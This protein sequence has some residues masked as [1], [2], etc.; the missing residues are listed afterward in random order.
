M[1]EEVEIILQQDSVDVTE[2]LVADYILPKAS[3]TTLGG[4]KIGD[5]INISNDGHI[6]V[7]MASDGTLG[8]IKIGTGLS[9]DANGVVTASGEYELPQATK[10]T[11]GGV[12]LDDE[13]N[14]QSVNPVQNATLTTV[15]SGIDSNVT[16]LTNS[17]DD[18]TETVTDVSTAVTGMASTVSTLNSTVSGL[19]TTVS[20]QSSAIATNT[21]D[22]GTINTTLTNHGND[23]ATIGGQVSDLY[24]DISETYTYEDI[25]DTIWTAGDIEIRGKG[26]Y[27]VMYIQLE[28]TLSIPTGSSVTL[29]TLPND[30]I[31]AYDA[32]GGADIVDG[33]ISIK[34]DS[35][36][37]NINLINNNTTSVNVGKL[38]ASIPIIYGSI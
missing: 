8:L 22:I 25:D 34:V 9:I 24:Q 11:L 36:N 17:V 26:F 30:A 7:P 13:L 27:A 4:V 2:P 35:T 16:D 21:S 18:L 28:G 12:Y 33:S 31:P 23:I 14:D 5:N 10:T 19:S 3:S 29:Y 32:F 38:N 15:I 1:D 6:S 20:G 37:G